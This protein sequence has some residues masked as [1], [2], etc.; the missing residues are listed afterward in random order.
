ME[1]SYVLGH[2]GCE[3]SRLMKQA[4][5]I[6]PITRGFFL[7]AGLAPTFDRWFDVVVGRSEVG[8]W[9]YVRR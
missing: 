8:A 5:L 3:L 1:G 2:S 4:R 6:D 9:A 7:D